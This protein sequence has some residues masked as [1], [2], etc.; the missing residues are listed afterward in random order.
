MQSQS[1]GHS[2]LLILSGCRWVQ[3]AAVILIL[4]GAWSLG[5]QA[6]VSVLDPGL[7]AVGNAVSGGS[8]IGRVAPSVG[9]PVGRGL[10]AAGGDVLENLATA[11]PRRVVTVSV[12][13]I[14]AGGPVSAV[15]AEAVTQGLVG[16][17]VPTSRIEGARLDL[18][19]R[20]RD[21]GFPLVTV[22]AALTSDGTLRYTVTEGRIVE[23]KLDGDIGPAGSKVLD[24]LNN[25]VQPGPVNAARLERWLLMAQDVPGVSLQTVLRPSE[26][27]PGSLTLVARVS[28]SAVSGYVA[29]DNRAYRF[30][31]PE[32]VLGLVG[33]NSFTSFGERTEFSLYRSLLNNTQIFGQAALE[34]F[35]GS[36]GLKVR[37]YAGAGDTQPG[38]TLRTAGYDGQ[39]VVAG[40]QVS[41]P[42][43][44]TRQ[45]KLNLLGVFDMI[46]SAVFLGGATGPSSKDSLRVVRLGADYALQDLVFGISRPAVNQVSARLSH[47]LPFLGASHTGSTSLG[48][49][50]STVEYTKFM[51]EMS[52]NQTLFSPWQDASVNLLMQ[53]A[54]Q[55]SRD[56]IPSAEKY[57]LG[58]MRFTRGFYAGQ[59]TGDNAVAGTLEVQL[60]TGLAGEAFG[61][62]YD[63]GLQFYGFYDTGQT[64]EN[65]ALD[66]NRRLSSFGVGVRAALTSQ[67]ELDIEGVSR[68][69]R[70][71]ESSSGAIKPLAEKAMYWRLLGRF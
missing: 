14:T 12:N 45:Q 50:G 3:A 52:R 44:V 10:S 11:V 29:M 47:G 34:G 39:S 16:P 54:G 35:V 40:G 1:Y 56:V 68:L 33:F 66:A 9:L 26:S 65:R 23:V 62:S 37:L 57:Y 41:Y 7:R 60:N 36:S 18:L 24:F 58:G 31:G 71:P 64:F 51:I 15:D 70:S 49:Q 5:A 6:Q 28:R 46:Q 53:V 8:P 63:M 19:K 59:V 67:L 43:V 69:T 42:L 32:Q 55:G 38:G 61:A 22:A 27:E 13:G 30:S 17:A 20:Y 21:A 25:L 4:S 2:R 48:R